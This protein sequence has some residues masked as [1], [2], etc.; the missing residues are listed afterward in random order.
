M[1][2]KWFYENKLWYGC[3]W[4]RHRSL[5]VTQNT[6]SLS[7]SLSLLFVSFSLYLYILKIYSWINAN[8]Y[9]SF[10]LLIIKS[11]FIYKNCLPLSKSLLL[12]L[13][14]SSY[15]NLSMFYVL[16]YTI[17]CTSSRK[18]VWIY[19]IEDSPNRI[20]VWLFLAYIKFVK[21]KY[22]IWQVPCIQ[23]E[24]WFNWEMLTTLC[25]HWQT[26]PTSMTHFTYHTAVSL[27]ALRVHSSNVDF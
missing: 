7:H 14:S 22:N 20:N 17:N 13:L 12:L 5:T 15:I 3:G 21:Y 24:Y 18:F 27:T 19:R 2:H 9:F 26:Y 23:S 8:I 11:I 25:I 16:S 10:F 6:L 1:A 4:Q